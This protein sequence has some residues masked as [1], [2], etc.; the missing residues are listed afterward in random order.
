M[1]PKKPLWLCWRGTRRF[2]AREPLCRQGSVSPSFPR[3]RE[4]RNVGRCIPACAG[5][6]VGGLG[7]GGGVRGGLGGA[8]AIGDAA[9]G[10]VVWAQLDLHSVAQ[11][12]ADMEFAHLAGCVGKHL[13]TRIE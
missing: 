3:R 11:R 1:S 5:M 13:L 4:S 8:L 7:A 9:A 10:Q 12:H 6:T 2:S